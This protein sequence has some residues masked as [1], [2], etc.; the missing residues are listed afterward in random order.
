MRVGPWRGPAVLGGYCAVGPAIL[1]LCT[2]QA[3]AGVDLSGI[4]EEA[5]EW[6]GRKDGVCSGRGVNYSW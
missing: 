6:S 4:R 3:A 5:R 2:G 1:Q